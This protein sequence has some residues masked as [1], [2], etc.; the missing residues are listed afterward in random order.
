VPLAYRSTMSQA[1]FLGN[2]FQVLGGGR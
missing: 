1:E 2:T